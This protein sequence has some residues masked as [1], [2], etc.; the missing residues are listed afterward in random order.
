MVK[1]LRENIILE[2]KMIKYLSL[3]EKEK[4]IF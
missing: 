2:N 3:R 1:V 4:G